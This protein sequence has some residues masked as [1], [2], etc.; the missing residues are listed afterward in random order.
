MWRQQAKNEMEEAAAAAA[1]AFPDTDDKAGEGYRVEGLVE[2]GDDRVPGSKEEGRKWWRREMELRFL[3]GGDEEFEYDM[4]D[5]SE[6]F[7]DQA[8]EDRREEE[9]WFDGEEPAWVRDRQDAVLTDD[10]GAMEKG[11]TGQ[12]G[13]QDF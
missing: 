4:V 10:G 11:L 5:E 1:A 9:S 12:T 8:W 13:V 6:E 7:D 3:R 2:E